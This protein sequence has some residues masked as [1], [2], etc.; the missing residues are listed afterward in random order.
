MLATGVAFTAWFAAEF[1]LELL[2]Y[3]QSHHGWLPTTKQLSWAGVNNAKLVDSL[4]PIARAY[5]NV[6]AMLIGMVGLAI[7]LTANMHSPKLIDL[8]LK[9]RVNRI[10]LTLMAL[11]A[12]NTLFVLYIVGPEFA[13]MWAF[14]L[15]VGGSLVGWVVLVPYL[16]YVVRFLNPST[17]VRRLHEEALNIIDEAKAHKMNQ[18]LAQ[19]ELRERLFQL[20]TLIMKSIDPP[21]AR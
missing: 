6:L 3:A 11:G 12:A 8:F 2:R 18:E 4:S 19:A 1:G 9:D 20:G 21:T 15:A 10:V 5:N 17:V 7:P 16:F 14:R 13:P